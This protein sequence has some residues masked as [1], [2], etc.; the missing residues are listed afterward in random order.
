MASCRS[1]GILLDSGVVFVGSCK[2]V[3]IHAAEVDGSPAIIKVFDNASA[4][5]GKE[6]A[7]IVLSANQTVEFDMHGVLCSNGLYYE[8]TTGEA[9]VSIE[10]S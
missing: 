10:F 4:A 2:L 6:L 1:S 3:S 5:S 7:R 9:A 8:E